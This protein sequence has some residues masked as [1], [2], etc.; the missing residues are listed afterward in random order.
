MGQFPGEDFVKIPPEFAMSASAERRPVL[1]AALRPADDAGGD[2]A[3]RH[4]HRVGHGRRR[5]VPQLLV[6]DVR[7]L[8]GRLRQVR[9]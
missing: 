8:D 5:G 1:R 6:V 7:A 4:P 2:A 9:H 3:A